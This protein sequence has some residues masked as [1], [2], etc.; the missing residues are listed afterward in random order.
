MNLDE[1]TLRA[2]KINAMMAIKK[3]DYSAFLRKIF[4]WYS[5]T[6]YTP[7]RDVEDMPIVE[8][9]TAYYEELYD[10][11]EEADLKQ[12]SI[13]L[14]MSEQEWTEKLIAE[15]QEELAFM[16]AVQSKKKIEDIKPKTE[17]KDSEEGFAISFEDV[18]V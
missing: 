10:K 17:N 11:M 1:E 16:K 9:L 15:E 3:P 12:E 14:S 7:L 5:K 2:I 6:F 13:K 4:R 8:I 18:P